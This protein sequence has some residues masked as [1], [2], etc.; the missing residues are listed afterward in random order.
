MTAQDIDVKK[1]T[2]D[3]INLLRG[4]IADSTT[5]KQAVR[6]CRIFRFNFIVHLN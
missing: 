3:D 1:F 4:K 5:G 6:V 2:T